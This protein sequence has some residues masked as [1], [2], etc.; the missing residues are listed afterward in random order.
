MLFA[1]ALRSLP[2]LVGLCWGTR[3]V[4]WPILAQVIRLS[5]LRLL[6]RRRLRHT[7]LVVL[8]EGPVFA[9]SWVCVFG[10]A[11]LGNGRTARWWRRRAAEWA[12]LLDR[13]VLLDAPDPILTRRLRGRSKRDD[14]LRDFTDREI[15]E[16]AAAYRT[17]FAQVLRHLSPRDRVITLPTDDASVDRLVR[18]LGTVLDETHRGH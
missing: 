9:L 5:A 3:S 11:A 2:A 6:L 4:S 8:D 10:P 17:A 7:R 18:A 15:V 16:L 13:V 1:G 14:E 12:P